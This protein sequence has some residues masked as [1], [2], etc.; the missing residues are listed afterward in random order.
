[1][2]VHVEER[3]DIMQQKTSVKLFWT[4]EVESQ[5]NTGKR[6]GKVG[7]VWDSF[8]ISKMDNAGFNLEYMDPI[9]VGD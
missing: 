3:A 8:D 1:M 5:A 4:N 9:N 2:N 7:S 6:H